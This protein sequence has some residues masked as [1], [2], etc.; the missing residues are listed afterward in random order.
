MHL[1][2]SARCEQQ[3]FQVGARV[4]GLQFHLETTPESARLMVEH[5]RAELVAGEYV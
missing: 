4:I 3:A 5:G 1:A 2:R